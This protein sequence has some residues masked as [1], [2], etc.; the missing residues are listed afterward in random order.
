MGKEFFGCSFTEQYG[1]ECECA[2]CI[3]SRQMTIEYE[4]NRGWDGYLD[5]NNISL[6][7]LEVQDTTLLHWVL[8]KFDNLF[9]N[10]ILFS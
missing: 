9:T 5:V 2:K 3:K 6:M 4:L 7:P 8:K 1:I 10:I